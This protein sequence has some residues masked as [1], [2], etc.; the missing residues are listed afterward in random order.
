MAL[1]AA[2]AERKRK[3]DEEATAKAIQEAA[4]RQALLERRKQEKA[5]ALGPEPEKGPDV[6]E[7]YNAY[8]LCLRVYSFLGYFFWYLMLYLH[9]FLVSIAY[10]I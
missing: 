8:N 3:E 10:A 6:T 1:E 4:E 9:F 2:E 7:V 5:M